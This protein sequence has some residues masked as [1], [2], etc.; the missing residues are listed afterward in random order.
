MLA[1]AKKLDL[2]GF[3]ALMACLVVNGGSKS[4]GSHGR[5]RRLEPPSLN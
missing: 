1:L 4:S 3:I 2:P 5:M